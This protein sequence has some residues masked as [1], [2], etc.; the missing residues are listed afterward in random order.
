M[1]TTTPTD[2]SPEALSIKAGTTAAALT[3]LKTQLKI[4]KKTNP[5]HHLYLDLIKFIDQMCLLINL[6]DTPYPS[7]IVSTAFK[8]ALD[9]AAHTKKSTET[10]K[11]ITEEIIPSLAKMICAFSADDKKAHETMHVVLTYFLAIKLIEEDRQKSA[12]KGRAGTIDQKAY[13]VLQKQEPRMSF[14]SVRDLTI[15]PLVDALQ[16]KLSTLEH[17]PLTLS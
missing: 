3:A 2:M 14:L 9:P 12:E 11:K 5:H 17:Q 8:Y 16:K 15:T 7:S 6:L 4:T 13:E 1:P 10:V